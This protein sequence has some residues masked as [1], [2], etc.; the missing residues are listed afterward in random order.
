MKE[1]VALKLESAKQP[2]QVLK[3]EVTVLR[4][5]QG[6]DHVC[7]FLGG[8]TNELYNYVVMTLQGKNLAELRRGQTRQCFSLSTSLRISLQILQS[9][10]SIHAIGF[11]HRDIKPSN[12]SMGR[13]PSTCRKVFMLD[14]GL[15]RKY[16]N[17]EGNVRAARPQAGFR[18]TVRY[19]SVNAH[20]NKEM[21]RHDD[22]WSLFYM[23]IEFVTGQLPWRRVKD[24]EQVGQM[25]EKYDHTH[26]L[27]SLPSEFKQILEH[28]QSLRYEDKPDYELLQNLFR[29]SIARRG[30]KD[31][32]AYDWEREN[33]SFEDEQNT[34]PAA[35]SNPLVNHQ[36]QVVSTVNN[37]ISAEMT[38]AM[39]TAQPSGAL[40]T[41]QQATEADTYDDRQKLTKQPSVGSDQTQ[42][43]PRR[44]L[45]KT[46]DRNRRSATVNNDRDSSISKKAQQQQQQRTPLTTTQISELSQR[47]KR[48]SN[49]KSSAGEPLTPT[50]RL[51]GKDD[52][53]RSGS[54]SDSNKLRNETRNP[55]EQISSSQIPPSLPPV[56]MYIPSGTAESGKPPKTPRSF[57]T[58][59][60]RSEAMRPSTTT[61][62]TRT[63]D[64]EAISNP[65]AT[66][67]MKVGPQ[68]VM[69]QWIVSLDDNLDDEVSD[70]QP[71]A[72]WEDAQD[73]L[74]STTHEPSQYHPAV[75]SIS[76][77]PVNPSNLNSNIQATLK[78]TEFNEMNL[79]LP[80]ENY[81]R[82]NEDGH[83][84]D[85]DDEDDDR[86]QQQHNKPKLNETSRQ[87]N[88]VDDCCSR[89]SISSNIQR[90][91]SSNS[92]L[93]MMM[94]GNEN[95]GDSMNRPVNSSS[96]SSS[97]LGDEHR[98]LKT[99]R[100]NFVPVASLNNARIIAK[101]SEQLNFTPTSILKT[102]TSKISFISSLSLL[103]LFSFSKLN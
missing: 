22:L 79:A 43:S 91:N 76:S 30:Y 83:D 75:S 84:G 69:S 57:R 35:T 99:R 4:R 3:M 47:L 21:G 78:N 6:K 15:A 51:V 97:L 71:S 94:K 89:P 98:K 44:S 40:N 2:K 72:K 62:T 31:S 95:L 14:F 54:H 82:I 17:S 73:K 92:S 34:A 87:L 93:L 81:R 48:P 45:Q 55:D 53:P 25:K 29:T 65:A 90:I 103:L 1:N 37:K 100:Y 77:P 80:F 27:K 101:S 56:I 9:I 68:T 61:T 96:S 67:A 63:C 86:Q 28:I 74:Q 26:F 85:V 7:K 10:E 41:R 23:L 16:T 13:L 32:D 52:S 58:T 8:G 12:F 19:A 36:T 60:S 20:K 46:L 24:K 11:L 102:E 38:K 64:S 59:A 39:M 18:G 42:F 66:Y 49:S 50:S 70:N 33:V 5:L 88:V